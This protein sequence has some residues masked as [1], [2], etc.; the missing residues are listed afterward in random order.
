VH[1]VIVLFVISV[2]HEP[3]LTEL[4]SDVAASIHGEL[5]AIVVSRR[6]LLKCAAI[7]TQKTSQGEF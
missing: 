2:D 5:V 6:N 4:L 1:K 7:A 3:T